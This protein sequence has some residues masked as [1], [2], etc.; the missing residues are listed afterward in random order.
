MLPNK[1]TGVV[2]FCNSPN[3]P[4]LI[5]YRLVH[6]HYLVCIFTE[7]QLD[8]RMLS[9]MDIL[10]IIPIHRVEINCP[11]PFSYDLNGT[12]CAWSSILHDYL[13]RDITTRTCAS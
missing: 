7:R 9:Y 10:D 11:L 8:V 12:L 6:T 13:V 4:S 5:A 1:N 3:R 2:V